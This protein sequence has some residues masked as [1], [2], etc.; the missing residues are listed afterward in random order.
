MTH[1]YVASVHLIIH[2][3]GVEVPL[4]SFKVNGY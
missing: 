1:E 4:L 2:F 3:F